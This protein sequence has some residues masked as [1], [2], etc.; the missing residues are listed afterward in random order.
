MVIFGSDSQSCVAKFSMKGIY[1]EFQNVTAM[2]G[3][4]ATAMN[5]SV[6]QTFN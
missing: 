5:I 2:S 3:H 1:I 4:H 6:Q